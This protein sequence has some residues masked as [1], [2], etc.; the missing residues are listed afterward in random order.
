MT[1]ARQLRPWPGMF[2]PIWVAA[3]YTGRSEATIRTWQKQLRISVV[4]D[5]GTRELLVHLGEAVRLSQELPRRN[6]EKVTA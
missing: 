3:A 4:C 6:R 5:A 1:T 2:R